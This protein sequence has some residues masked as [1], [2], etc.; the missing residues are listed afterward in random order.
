MTNSTYDLSKIK[1]VIFDMDGLMFNTEEIYRMAQ[2]EMAR[3]RGK[4]FTDEIHRGMMGKASGEDV[5]VMLDAWGLDE[6]QMKAFNERNELFLSFV[7]DHI[8]PEKGLMRLIEVLSDNN[9]RM[10]I[11]SGSTKQIIEKNVTKYN[12]QDRFEYILSGDE[13][14]YGK[15]DPEMYLKAVGML[16]STPGQCLVIEDSVNGVISGKKAGCAVFAVPN[17]WSKDSDF[18]QADAVFDDLDQIADLFDQNY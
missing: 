11:A 13:V 17:K 15:P 1:A 4:E 3:R 12:V 8:E 16:R 6:D 2:T 5:Q 9:M 10:M 7:D 14:K 18:S